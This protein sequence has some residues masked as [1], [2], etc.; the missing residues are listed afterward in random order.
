LGIDGEERRV[1]AAAEALQVGE[2]AGAAVDAIDVDAVAVAV[3]L[4]RRVAADIGEQRAGA[5]WFFHRT[6]RR[7]CV[8]LQ[9]RPDRQ[10]GQSV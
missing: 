1:L 8:G 9:C 4:G 3:P 5:C 7:S 2:G 6:S 10:V